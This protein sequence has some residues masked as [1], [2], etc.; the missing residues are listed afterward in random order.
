VTPLKLASAAALIMILGML[1]AVYL[2]RDGHRFSSENPPQNGIPV[3]LTFALPE[4][5][6]VQVVG[7]FNSWRPQQCEMRKEP[8]GPTWTVT[9]RLPAGRYEYAFLVD[10]AS[11]LS[12]PG[13]VGYQDDGFGNL[14]SV[15]V[16]GNNH[17]DAI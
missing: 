7:S 4:A 3:V 16:V 1:P 6:S 5:R 9:L 14:N 12:D 15:L 10:G 8:E 2:S 13:A 11:I 17:E